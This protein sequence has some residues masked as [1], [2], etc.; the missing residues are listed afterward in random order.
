MGTSVCARGEIDRAR[1]RFV[2]VRRMDV[3]RSNA[4]SEYAVADATRRTFF[5][6]GL[7]FKLA[8]V[9]VLTCRRARA[10]ARAG[11]ARAAAQ[12][13]AI[14]RGKMRSMRLDRAS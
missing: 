2:S 3:T 1:V 10:C 8:H 11:A 13:V 7:P 4:R 9:V 6:A 14:A 5:P 12:V